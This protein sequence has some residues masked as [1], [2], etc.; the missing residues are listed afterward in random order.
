MNFSLHTPCDIELSIRATTYYS[1]FGHIHSGAYRRLIR[2]GGGVA[3]VEFARGSEPYN[4]RASILGSRGTIDDAVLAS[5]IAHIVNADTRHAP[6]YAFASAHPRLQHVIQPLV[7][8]H[9]F[10]FEHFFDALCVTIIEQ[11]ISL[12]AAQL[13]ERWI[14]RWGGESLDYHG[15]TYFTFPSPQRLAQATPD[16]LTPTK[17]TFIRMRALIGLAQAVTT[18]QLDLD[19]LRTVPF[20]VAYPALIA[21]KGVGHWTA[22]WSIIRTLGH[23]LYIGRADVALRSAVNRYFFDQTGRA[24][25]D[26]MDDLFASFG[27]YDGIAAYYT[28]MRYAFEKY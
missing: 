9:N 13:A 2:A 10:R 20:A 1:A 26:V 18:A 14:C 12:R 4:I 8:L 15:T 11:Q 7:G 6:F 16:D 3:L 19:A 28:I 23:F 17:I 5:H 24:D 25:P 27:E 22:A 21:L